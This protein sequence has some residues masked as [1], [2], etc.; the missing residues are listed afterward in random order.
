MVF[1]RLLA[2]LVVL[3]HVAYVSFVAGGLLLNLIGCWRGWRWVGNFWFR[4]IH[5][6][7]IAV[8]VAESLLGI[9]CPLTTLENALRAR[10]GDSGY[11]GSFVGRML[12]ELLFFDAPTWVFTVCY[13]GFGLA[14]LA[15]FLLAPPRWPG[16]ARPKNLGKEIDG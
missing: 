3:A 13:C 6:L 9:V 15:T 4:A 8:V 14:V 11:A 2:D 7:A 12:H 16:S 1:Y 5:L 10:A